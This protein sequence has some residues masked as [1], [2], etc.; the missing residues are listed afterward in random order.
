MNWEIIGATGEWAAA[1]TVVAS[2]LYL[3]R[4][5]RIANQQSQAAARYSFLDA[6]GQAN[7]AIGESRESAAIFR[8]GLAR[9][10]L[11]PDEFMQFFVL[12]GQFLNTWNVM[13]YLH[14]ENQLPSTQ[15]HIVETD[16]Q[17]ALSTPGGRAFWQE[18]GKP[19]S[20][21]GF[22]KC[23]DDLISVDEAP[24]QIL[25]EQPGHSGPT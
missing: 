12:L 2:L 25:G 19:N 5:I 7:A 9:E 15:W 14:Q 24:Y 3:A 21:K 23:V 22:I 8:R 17:A 18:I 16:I 10:D 13:Y 4:Q 1:I 20:P 11:D 6:Y